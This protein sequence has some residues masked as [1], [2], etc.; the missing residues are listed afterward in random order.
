MN[1]NLYIGRMYTGSSMALLLWHIM[2]CN[3]DMSVGFSRIWH[4]LREKVAGLNHCLK[5]SACNLLH[6]LCIVLF[7]V[8]LLA[9]SWLMSRH[10]SIP[11]RS[12]GSKPFGVMSRHFM[13]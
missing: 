5:A 10:V 7:L 3:N 1:S 12:Q 6:V 11:L 9:V 8:W 2:K 13:S 4:L